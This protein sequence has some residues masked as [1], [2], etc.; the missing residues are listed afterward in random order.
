MPL[1]NNSASLEIWE[2]RSNAQGALEACPGQDPE[3]AAAAALPWVLD[4]SGDCGVPSAVGGALPPG[5]SAAACVL[6]PSECVPS[7]WIQKRAHVV[8]S[9]S[10]FVVKIA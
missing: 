10:S 8:T 9:F 6:E 5:A 3:L 2:A 4:G 1:C 7:P